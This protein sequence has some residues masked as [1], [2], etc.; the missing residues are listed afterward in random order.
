MGGWSSPDSI[1]IADRRDQL[2]GGRASPSPGRKY[3]CQKFV[4]DDQGGRSDALIP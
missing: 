1:S 4:E 2:S 3:S